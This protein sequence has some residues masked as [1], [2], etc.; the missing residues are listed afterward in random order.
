MISLLLLVFVVTVVT[1]PTFDNWHA[2]R[3]LLRSPWPTAKV[4][5]LPSAGCRG[6]VDEKIK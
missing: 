5:Y 1:G 6:V 4:L 3:K 2:R